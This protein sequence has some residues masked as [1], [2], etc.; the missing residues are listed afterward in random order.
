MY[1]R[2]NPSTFTVL[3]VLVGV[4]TLQLGVELDRPVIELLALFAQ[5]RDQLA[6]GLVGR[7]GDTIGLGDRISVQARL[8]GHL[9]PAGGGLLQG[10][11]EQVGKRGQTHVCKIAHYAS[12]GNPHRGGIQRDHI[13]RRHAAPWRPFG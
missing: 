8:V 10:P 11:A 2:R 9:D 4:S 6:R 5:P 7:R 1:R 13:M 12:L 3:P